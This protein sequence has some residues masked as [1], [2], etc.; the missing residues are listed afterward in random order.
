M[1][2]DLAESIA[3]NLDELC[4]SWPDRHV[5]GP[6]VLA[7]NR[8]FE[9]RVREA[10]WA[11][12]SLPFD[13][14]DWQHGEARLTTRDACW[15]LFPGPYSPPFRGDVLLLAA[16]TVEE[17]ESLRACGHAALLLHG[18]LAAEQITPRRYPFYRMASHDRVL[19]A[20]DAASPAA[21]IA[22]TDRTPMAAAL[23]PFPLFEDGDLGFPSAYLL[24]IEGDELLAHAGEEVRLAI[25][26]HPV[27][28]RSDQVVARLRGTAPGRVLIS[29]HID[30]RH[31][32][33]GALD[34]ATG[35]CVLM[36]VAELLG[37]ARPRISVELLPFNG[38]DNFAA[39]GE[40][41]YLERYGS[42]PGD[43]LLAINIDAAGRRGDLSAYSFYSCDD[44]LRERVRFVAGRHAGIA[45]G[46][47][48]PMSDHMVFAMR[49]IPAMAVTST[50]L[51][52]I[53]ATVAHTS[54][55]VP[56]LADADLLAETARFIVDTVRAM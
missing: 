48:W 15:D 22:S 44:E 50:G 32:T 26:S 20:L 14:I 6:G 27:P 34:N 29:A 43:V 17:L 52:E 5:G 53:A 24:D 16:S 25:E 28:A 30:S 2:S 42:T 46:P 8:L 47:E 13:C 40:V 38:E 55:D 41:E 19:A 18:E 35:V 23:R 45:E 3:R 12:E 56:S 10:G 7:A 39:Y 37:S 36:A 11:T 1:A 54:A 51:T 49:G 31:G 33:P 9:Q 21:V 4:L